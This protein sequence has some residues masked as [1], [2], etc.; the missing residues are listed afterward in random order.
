[1]TH[2]SGIYK[3]VS[4]IHPEKIYIGSAVDFYNRRKD[5]KTKLLHGKHR[6]PKLTTHYNKY[7]WE[8]FDFVEVERCDKHDLLIREQYYID[9]LNP[10][11][12]VLRS[13][14][15]AFG[16]VHPPHIRKIIADSA[17]KPIFQFTL[18]GDFI[19][20]WDSATDAALCL[21]LNRK[22]ISE[23]MSPRRKLQSSQGFIWVY[24]DTYDGGQI[25]MAPGTNK[26]P[27]LQFDLSGNFI[28]EWESARAAGRYYNRNDRNI[29]NSC[30]GHQCNV[31]GFI[32]KYKDPSRI[33]K[34]AQNPI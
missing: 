19:K 24:K 12:N 21:G 4:K 29:T 15:N 18:Q 25:K 32:W 8:G 11:F 6:N 17:K 2:N 30:R 3:I 9:L 27:I 16:M 14:G 20:E 28:R 22:G 33:L 5:H 34:M 23:S 10:W 26:V 13:A 31:A 7:G 1:M